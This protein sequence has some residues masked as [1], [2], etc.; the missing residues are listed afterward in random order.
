MMIK[1]LI[2]SFIVGVLTG[3]VFSFFSLPIPAPTVLA[4]IFGIFGI[5]IGY[6]LVKLAKGG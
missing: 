3:A 6:V 5:Y 1:D 2:K 4:G